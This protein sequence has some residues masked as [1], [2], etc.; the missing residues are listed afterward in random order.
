[1]RDYGALP[2]TPPAFLEKACEKQCFTAKYPT[3][4]IRVRLGGIFFF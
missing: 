3:H 1:M 2:H 4:F